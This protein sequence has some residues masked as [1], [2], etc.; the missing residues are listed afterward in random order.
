MIIDSHAHLNFREY[1]DNLEDVIKRSLDCNT[2]II[3]V[4][5]NFES[6]QKA[7]AIA[8]KYEGIWAVIGCHPNHL[9]KDFEEKVYFD[10]EESVFSTPKEKFDY[11][12]Y[13]ELARSSKK[14]VGIGET[15]LDFFRMADKDHPFE[16]VKEIQIEVFKQY[17]KLA[18]ELD[19][20]LVLH[21]RG[22]E[23]DNFKAY[24]MMI[25]IL[26]SEGA[27]KG[28]IHCYG[29]NLDQAKKF[30]DMGFYVGFTG[31]VTFKNAKDLQAIAKEIA[32]D[33]ILVETDAPFLAPEPY[34]GKKNEPCFTKYIVQKIADLKELTFA[35]VEEATYENAKELFKI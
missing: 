4:G 5:S 1:E 10:K 28:V 24:D 34:R 26:H 23:N 22:E 11:K 14:V 7:V 27:K 2:Q 20:P 13:F 16:Q 15:G 8:D 33:K 29:G 35:E 21:C 12:K 25:D 3:T 18:K 9:V 17:I 6:S 31:I 30:I 32:L 19:L